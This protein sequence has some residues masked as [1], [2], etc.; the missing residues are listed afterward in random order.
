MVGLCLCFC[1][2]MCVRVCVYILMQST[3]NANIILLTARWHVHACSGGMDEA[4]VMSYVQEPTDS[5][6]QVMINALRSY[7]YPTD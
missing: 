7:R 2:C 1:V 4:A 3:L 6:T 5:Q